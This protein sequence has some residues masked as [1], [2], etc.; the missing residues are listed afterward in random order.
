MSGI[1]HAS[2]FSGSTAAKVRQ[3]PRG[4]EPRAGAFF[5][6]LIYD[7]DTYYGRSYSAS[8]K[9]SSEW[10]ERAYQLTSVRIN[11]GDKVLSIS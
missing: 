5:V 2:A 3:A 8:T 10:A 7:L 6:Q 4:I 9:L 11:R 1:Y